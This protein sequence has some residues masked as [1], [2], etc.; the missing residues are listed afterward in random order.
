MDSTNIKQDNHWGNTLYDGAGSIGI[1]MANF[2]MIIG[3]ILAVFLA[4]MG[5]YIMIND[6]DDNYFR[7]QGKVTEPNCVKTS[8]T[9]D[10]KGRSVDNY[11]CNSIVSYIID[12][13][14]YFKNIYMTK[15]SFYIKD[16]PI[17]LMVLKKDHTDVKLSY[18]NRTTIGCAA[19]IFAISIVG[20]AYLNYYLTYNYKM[21]AAAQGL[22]TLV[23]LFY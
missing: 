13:Y 8:I 6:Y 16:E 2:S 10:D 5:I 4:V 18:I 15:T 11:K 3:I 20:I 19:M 9:Y 7:I 21:F 1:F 23:G 14:T 22:S 12:N 17:D